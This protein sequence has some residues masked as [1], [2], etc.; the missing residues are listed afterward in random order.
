MFYS[1]YL[2]KG[3]ESASRPAA[4]SGPRFNWDTKTTRGTDRV[5]YPEGYPCTV[6]LWT[7]FHDELRSSDSDKIWSNVLGICLQSQLLGRALEF[8]KGTS[9]K[10]IASEHGV[11][12]IVKKYSIHDALSSVSD[13]YQDFTKLLNAG[14]DKNRITEIINHGFARNLNVFRPWRDSRAKKPSRDANF[15]GQW[16]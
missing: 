15:A 3:L 9:D 2:F 14:R 12:L 16:K 13:V 5:E 10:E 7:I 1:F 4:Q 11:Y 8:C 6:K